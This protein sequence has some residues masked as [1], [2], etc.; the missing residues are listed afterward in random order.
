MS[1]LTVKREK[2]EHGSQIRAS[3]GGQRFEPLRF[4][5]SELGREIQLIAIFAALTI[6]CVSCT[7]PFSTR[8]PEVPNRGAS[9]WIP[10]QSADIVLVNLRNAVLQKNVENYLR[11]LVDSTRSAR[12]FRFEPDQSAAVGNPGVFAY[13][14]VDKERFYLSQLFAVL[15]DDSLRT[16]DFALLSSNVSA[17]TAEFTETYELEIH[18]TQQSQGLPVVVRGQATFWLSSDALGNWAV[19]RW[20]DFGTGDDPTWSD[21]KAAFG[22]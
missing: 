16:L 17:D 2:V 9:T 12:R 1:K 11:S 10:P 19:Y 22:K 8:D 15:P 18:H 14:D 4:S 21:L 20:A 6:C 5:S 3:A 7:N 13:W